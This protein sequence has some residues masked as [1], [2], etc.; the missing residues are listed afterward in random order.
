M[1]DC[2]AVIGRTHFGGSRT[3][4]CGYRHATRS[5]PTCT[6]PSTRGKRPSLFGKSWV[7]AD[8]RSYVVDH[9]G[10]FDAVWVVDETGDVRKGTNTVGV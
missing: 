9:L 8:L 5:L 1:N 6:A 3:G 10:D 7:V 2:R 4:W